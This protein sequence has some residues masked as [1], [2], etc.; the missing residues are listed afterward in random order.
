VTASFD[1]LFGPD[2]ADLYAWCPE[3]GLGGRTPAVVPSLD[4]EC[5]VADLI[6]QCGDG[7]WSLTVKLGKSRIATCGF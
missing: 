1:N 7:T 2:C 6:L 3:G 5:E 4:F